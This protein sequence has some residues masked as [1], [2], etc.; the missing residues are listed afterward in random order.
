MGMTIET[1]PSAFLRGEMSYTEWTHI[2]FPEG[3]PD[4]TD[5]TVL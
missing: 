1:E 3:K 5:P 2:R 4:V